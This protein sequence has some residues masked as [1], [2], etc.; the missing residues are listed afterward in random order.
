[1]SVG[2]FIDPNIQSLDGLVHIQA[3]LMRSYT[4]R[5]TLRKLD[6]SGATI[7]PSLHLYVGFTWLVI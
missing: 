7:Y 4:A 3:C 5:T 2:T 1:M 6:Y